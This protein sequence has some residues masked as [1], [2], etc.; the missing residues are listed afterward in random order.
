MNKCIKGTF[1][2]VRVQLTGGLDGQESED[3]PLHAISTQNQ[4]QTH[5]IDTYRQS[6]KQ[7]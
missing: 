3:S 6:Y 4:K 7:R 1:C 2:I 5:Q